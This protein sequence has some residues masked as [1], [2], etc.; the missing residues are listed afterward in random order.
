M[1]ADS[2]TVLSNFIWRLLERTGAQVVTL[3]VSIVLARIL[4]PKDYGTIALIN[5]FINVLAVFVNGGF[6]HALIQ[7]K[8]ADETDFSTVFYAQMAVCVVLYACVFLFAP[9]IAKFYDNPEISPMIRVLGLTLIV[10][11]VKNV[12]TAYVSRNMIFK[13]FFFAT[14]GGTIGAAIV[15]IR[16]A[17]SGYGAWALICQSLLNNTVDTLILWITVKWR[18]KKTFSFARLKQL[19]SYGWKLLVSGLLDTGYNEL[20]SLVIGKTY[21]S[22]DLAYYA[23]G[24][25]WPK[26]I[27]TNVNASIDSVLLP[28]LSLEQDDKARIKAMTRRA[29]KTSTYVI[30]PLL[31]GLAF[32]GKPLV[33]WVLTEKWLPI[34]PFQV[35]FCF[36]Y[37]FYPIH[38]ANLNAIKAIGRSDLFL[39][40]EIIKKSIGLLLLILAVPI[41]PLAIAVSLLISSVLSQMI[42]AWPN[43]KLLDYGYLEQLKDILPNIMLAVCMGFAVYWFAYLPIHDA[44]I[45]CIQITVGA[46]IYIGCSALFRFES[47]KYIAENLANYRSLKKRR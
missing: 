26:L 12:Q 39:R 27:I 28:S 40:M 29:I 42:N 23:K 33:R 19:F 2:K 32:C 38:T 7:K 16:M 6:S 9:L 15:G 45:L 1:K 22:T 25:S 10:S 43:R 36:S 17:V 30:A 14:L 3:A 47:F 24:D 41:S 4:L 21:T 20:R 37:I 46:G 44:L 8:D 13:K 31:M 34:V 35:I 11:G 5:I 18:P